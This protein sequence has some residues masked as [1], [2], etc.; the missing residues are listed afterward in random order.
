MICVVCVDAG[1]LVYIVGA[2]DGNKRFADLPADEVHN[3]PSNHKEGIIKTPTSMASWKGGRFVSQDQVKAS[4]DVLPQEIVY[5][6]PSSAD[7]GILF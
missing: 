7:G 5:I 1:R 4:L 6:E 3:R 2:L